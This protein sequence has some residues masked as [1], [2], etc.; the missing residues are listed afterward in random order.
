MIEAG[1]SGT[2]GR[3]ADRVVRPSVA[4]YAGLG[5]IV[6][7]IVLLWL[8][9][10]VVRGGGSGAWQ[11]IALFVGIYAVWCVAVSRRKIVVTRDGIR[12]NYLIA[13]ASMA[14]WDE[15]RESRVTYWFD[16]S[17]VQIWVYCAESD[18]LVIPLRLYSSSDRS[19][20]QSLAGLRIVR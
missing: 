9:V 20:L 1:T 6:L 17:P 15:I 8:A 2:S 10:W 7:G 14:R 13:A 18:P 19:Y 11:P 5:V 4:A 3:Y 12:C 16:R